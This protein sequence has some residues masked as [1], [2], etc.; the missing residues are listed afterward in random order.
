[1][2]HRDLAARNVLLSKH[3][4]AKI[5]DFG[6]SYEVKWNFK[7]LSCWKNVAGGGRGGRRPV[8]RALDRARDCAQVIMMI[9][10]MI[11]IMMLQEEGR[12]EG[13]EEVQ[14]QVRCLVFWYN[15]IILGIIEII[16]IS[17]NHNERNILIWR[18]AI[19]RVQTRQAWRSEEYIEGEE[20]N[21]AAKRIFR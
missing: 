17:R 11:M 3:N 21:A 9:M 16:M 15:L 1:M 12:K 14:S 19:Q 20:N 10:M 5:A 7:M 6:L 18:K 4:R 8:P 2:I 13:E